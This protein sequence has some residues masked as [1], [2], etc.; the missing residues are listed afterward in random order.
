[1]RKKKK[2]NVLTYLIAAVWFANGLFCK[3]LHLVPRHEEIVARV[4]G[5]EYAGPLTILIGLAEIVM[6][7]WV[8]TRF[9]SKLSA[10]AQMLIIGTMNIIEFT[11]A[12]DL[13]LWGRLNILFAFLFIGLIYFNEFVLLKKSNQ[14]SGA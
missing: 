7:I 8:L 11:L 14:S 1:M 5:E 12:P 9:Q 4:L 6:A 3:V 13:L 2:L 10:I